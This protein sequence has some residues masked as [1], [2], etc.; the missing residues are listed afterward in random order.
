MAALSLETQQAA[1][2][3][4][5]GKYNAALE[6]L[7]SH[8][9]GL[10]ERHL[11][12]YEYA[13]G[14][15]LWEAGKPCERVYFPFRGA[16][17]TVQYAEKPDAK[18]RLDAIVIALTGRDAAC[19]DIAQRSGRTHGV[20]L[21]EGVFFVINAAELSRLARESEEIARLAATSMDW[22]LAQARQIAFCASQCRASERIASFILQVADRAGDQ[23]IAITQD[24][25]GRS[26]GL[27]RES[28]CELLRT[29]MAQSRHGQI[30]FDR[31]YLQ[32][33]TC[34]CYAALSPPSWP[35]AGG[36]E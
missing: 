2:P 27:K 13:M 17:G 20:V 23:R 24:L 33:C 36:A 19:G 21:A 18:R 3:P 15:V 34:S 11:K 8:A 29:G 9:F 5:T 10:M 26:L 14:Q 31:K 28:V 22:M 30:L 7:S 16:I 6:A 25:L 32:T 35:F 4:P 12:R 1:V